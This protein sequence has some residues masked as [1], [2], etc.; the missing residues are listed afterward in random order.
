MIV[1]FEKWHGCLNNFIVVW[2]THIEAKYL[3]SSLQ[4]QASQLCSLKGDG[5]G[6]DGILML[7][8]QSKVDVIPE[9]LVIINSDGSIAKNCGN[10]IRCA[11]LSV[12]RRSEEASKHELHEL[13]LN[14]E[15]KEMIC[16]FHQQAG[17]NK[18][19]LVSVAMGQPKLNTANSWHNSVVQQLEPM[20]KE[21]DHP[22]E[23]DHIFTCDLANPHI[24]L[25]TQQVNHSLLNKLGPMLQK[26]PEHDGFNLHLVEA[27][28]ASEADKKQALNATSNSISEVQ[29]TL[30]W[31]RGVGPTSACG[32]GA[33]AIAASV[34]QDDFISREEWI[35]IAMPGGN[36]YAKQGSPEEDIILLGPATYVFS[37]KVE[38]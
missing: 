35:T 6:A 10:G 16:Q 32:S 19:V 3:K 15:D 28:D 27:T 22:Y 36:L 34:Y 24:V 21:L 7:I 12:Y 11:A 2:S 29:R 23:T 20:L 38:I 9:Q 25:F 26:L 1:E 14:V 37:G 33:C 4:K 18:K 17:S 13:S 31:E 8:A 5:I 30:T